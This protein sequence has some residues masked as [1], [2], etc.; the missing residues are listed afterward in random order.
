VLTERLR[1]VAEQVADLLDRAEPDQDPPAAEQRVLFAEA[2][3]AIRAGGAPLL[4][5]VTPHLWEYYGDRADAC[6]EDNLGMTPLA[7]GDDIWE[8]VELAAPPSL[9]VGFGP[10]DEPSP[11]Y[12]S[13]EGEVSWEPEHGLQ[14][15]FDHSGA[16]CRVGPYSG[17]L[18]NTG[19]FA[20]AVYG[21]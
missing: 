11:C 7:D 18:T 1:A 2:V 21:W 5:T 8:H 4:D 13:F 9:H 6:G 19:P 17:R 16:V 10:P 14:V 20:G 3:A 15:V 12:V